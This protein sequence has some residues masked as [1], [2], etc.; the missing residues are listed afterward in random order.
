[1]LSLLCALFSFLI[2]GFSTSGALWLITSLAVVIIL[3]YAFRLS[4]S[5]EVAYVYLNF[6]IATS[7]QTSGSAGGGSR[8]PESA[9][10]DTET[11]EGLKKNARGDKR[12]QSEK[13][14]RHEDR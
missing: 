5:A 4:R 14:G 3:G 8:L 13:G 10:T 6:L 7:A 9:Q 1:M 11:Q 12:N 2:N